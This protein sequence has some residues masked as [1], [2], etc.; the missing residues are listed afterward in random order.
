MMNDQL[1]SQDLYNAEELLGE[2]FSEVTAEEGMMSGGV[3]LQLG[4]GGEALQALRETKICFGNPTNQLIRLTPKLFEEVGVEL[5][6]IRKRQMRQQFDF[7]YLT[8]TVSLQPQRGAKFVRLECS[9]DFTPKGTNEPIVQTI[10][11]TSEWKEVLNWGAG[12]KLGLGGDLDFH[13]EVNLPST[14][15]KQLPGHLAAK[16]STQNAL[17]GFITIPDYSF[18]LGRA[19]IVATGEGNSLCFWRIENP[20]LQKVQTVQ[21]GVVFKVPKGTTSIELTGLVAA[22]PSINWL[23]AHVRNVFEYLSERMQALLRRR[24][25]NGS[26]RLPIGDYEKWT[27]ALSS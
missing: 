18:K 8:L 23:T 7:Y 3:K 15:I 1:R 14:H 24:E 12:M 10:F 22:E 27:L 6:E 4:A 25:R 21:F 2:L 5:T 16:V 26:E 9:L 19:D 11:P 17:K 20:D 13:S